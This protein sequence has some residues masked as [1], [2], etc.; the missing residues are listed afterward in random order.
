MGDE[1]ENKIIFNN[2]IEVLKNRDMERALSSFAEGAE[3]I[4]PEGKFSGKGEIERYLKWFGDNILAIR[5][6]DTGLISQGNCAACELVLEG[7]S[8]GE[9]WQ[10]T[11]L[12]VCEFVDGGIKNLRTVY[13]RLS[14]AR[15][16]ATEGLAGLAVSKI[17]ERME[18]G[19]N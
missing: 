3:W 11:A 2:F 16:V 6:A 7:N 15:Q 12:S 18:E 8:D 17:I 9:K 4:A 5:F 1:N 10:V 19:L 13:D 14:V